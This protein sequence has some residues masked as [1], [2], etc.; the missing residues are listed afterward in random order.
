MGDLSGQVALVTGASRGIGAAIARRLAAAGAR[1][2]V[3]YMSSVEAAQRALLDISGAGGSAV[4]IQAD[5]SEPAGIERLFGELD[6]S[7]GSLDIL[8]NN[9]GVSEPLALEAITAESIDRLFAVNFRAAAL[10]SR[11]AAARM[12]PGGRI[13]NIS[14]GA[15]R[16]APPGLS[17]Y[18]ATKA[19][20]D[21]FTLSTAAELGPGGI[22]VNAVAPG[23]VATDMLANTIPQ[24]AQQSLIGLTPMRRI[25]TPDD[26]ANVVEFLVSTEAAWITGAVIPVSGGLR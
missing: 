24:A 25:G 17:V 14:S 15:A 6:R 13:V 19:A 21:A 7:F 18:S 1:V 8:I 23:L 5:L 10:C 22:R 26:V 4:A 3:H 11:L 2:C 12:G 16:A 9:A 20:L